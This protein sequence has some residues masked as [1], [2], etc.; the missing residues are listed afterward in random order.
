MTKLKPIYES[1]NSIW[2]YLG[3]CLEVL[4]KYDENTI[5]C[6]FAD[7]PYLLSNNGFTCFSGRM[8]S[9][10]K[11][12]WDF[13]KGIEAD[14]KFH[15]KWL[16]ECK[17]ILKPSGTIWI[18]GTYHSVYLCGYILQLLGFHILNDISWYKPNAPP[19]ISCRY[20]TCSHETLIWAKKD[21]KSKHYFDYKLMKNGEWS[22]DR[23]KKSSSQMRTVW[24]ITAPKKS[25]KRF[26]KHPTQKPVELLKRI[27]LASTKERDLIL[28]PF[29]GSG[30]T[31]VV[32]YML[33]RRFIGIDNEKKYIQMSIR[34]LKDLVSAKVSRL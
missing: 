16:S 26:G 17:R 8:V 31:G 12:S 2:L 33:N 34:R 32:S 10:N 11:G 3:D 30:T 29:C 21:K 27:I 22:D 6:I 13:S 23:L 14:F 4:K 5:D 15:E 7:P 1:K 9:V 24:A 18:S 28:D 19:N 25:E 20:F